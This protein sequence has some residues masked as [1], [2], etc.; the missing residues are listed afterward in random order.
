MMVAIEYAQ[1]LDN[2]IFQ[3]AS[4]SS[5][6]RLQHCNSCLSLFYAYFAY[7]KVI[8]KILESIRNDK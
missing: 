2:V 6:K 4:N 7:T 3:P 1:T 5:E 8:W